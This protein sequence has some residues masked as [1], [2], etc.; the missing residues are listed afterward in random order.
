M[1]NNTGDGNYGV[2][3]EVCD[4][5]GEIFTKKRFFRTYTLREKFISK[6]YERDDFISVVS[7]CD[8]AGSQS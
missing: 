5:R 1:A 6:L 3:W 2:I 8:D 7:V 4:R